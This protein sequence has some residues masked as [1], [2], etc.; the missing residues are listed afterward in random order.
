MNNASTKLKKQVEDEI[1]QYHTELTP[2]SEGYD[3]SE[4]K[5]KRRIALFEN[6]TYPTGKFDKQKN[7]KYWF[8]IIAPRVESE[9]KN[10]DF[11]SKSVEAYS[12]RKIDELPNIIT[13]LKLGEYL[14]ITGQAEELNSAIEEGSAWGNVLWKRIKG[15]YERCDLK[16]V[17]IINQTAENVDETPIIERHQL[18]QS[19]LRSK[20][21]VW[22]TTNVNLVLENCKQNTFKSEVGNQEKDTT[23]PYYDIYERTGEVCLYDL[24]EINEEPT[25]DADKEKYVNAK[26]ITAGTK[27]SI[28][29]A[30]IEYVLFAEDLGKKKN[31]DLFKEFHRSRYKGRWFREGLYELLFDLQVRANQIGNQ[32]ARGLEYASKIVFTSPDKLIAQNF[33]SHLKNG[34]IVKATDLKHLEV[35]LSGFDQLIADWNRVIVMANEIANSREIVQGDSL[36]SGTPFRLGALYNQNANKL[37]VFIRQKLAIP[38]SEIF[39]QWIIPNL[40]KD[41]TAK[42]V[43][44]LTGDSEMLDRLYAFIVDNW[45]IRNLPIMPPHDNRF[46]QALRQEKVKELKARPQLLIKHIKKSFEDYKPHAYVNITGEQ[47]NLQSELES[48][49]SF[50]NLEMDPVRRTALIEVAMR[51]RGIDAGS[52]PKSPPQPLAPPTSVQSPGQRAPV[53]V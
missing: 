16:N 48:L 13:N 26:V 50:I 43:L 51:K 47:V 28:V 34:D 52:L 8:E 40:I 11:D 17:Y 32:L 20:L 9:V 1:Q 44:R 25:T 2:I 23:T 22:D 19:D 45:Y 46:G 18:S 24:K 6:K 42:E 29:G 7:Y 37:F 3:F 33:I 14:R 49:G 5:L 53:A 10:I 21:H 35:R 12:D 4:Y 15:G 36:P 30:T 41:I 39:E 38:F 31:S 27:G